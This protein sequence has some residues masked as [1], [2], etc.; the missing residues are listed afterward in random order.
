MER[1][2]RQAFPCPAGGK[3]GRQDYE[4]ALLWLKDSGLIRKVSLVSCRRLPLKAYEDLKAFKIYLLDFGLLRTMCEIEP[5]LIIDDERIFSEFNGSLTEQFVL[6]ELSAQRIAG[7]IY[8][9]SEEAASEV[10]FI[11]SHRNMIVPVEAKTGLSV[12]AQSLKV[13][14]GKYAPKVAVR[15]SLRDFRFNSGLLNLPLYELFNLKNI[16]EAIQ[17]VP[18]A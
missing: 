18:T 10:D 1:K 15:T 14:R 2:A 4:D 11:F 13:F 6:Q 8:Y 5:S 9:W 7:S 12:H 3:A 17:Q 16:L